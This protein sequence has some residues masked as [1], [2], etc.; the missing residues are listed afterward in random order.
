MERP[1][2]TFQAFQQWRRIAMQRDGL[3]HSRPS[4]I[5]RHSLSGLFATMGLYTLSAVPYLAAESN[6][7]AHARWL[8]TSKLALPAQPLATAVQLCIEPGWHTYWIN[9]GESGMAT[10]VRWQLPA[11]W[12]CSSLQHPPP[13]RFT[14]AGLTSF[15]HSG[16]VWF[17]VTVTPPGDFRGQVELHGKLSWL[18][19]NETGCFPGEATITLQLN[20]G[21]P[22]PSPHHAAILTATRAL[23]QTAKSLGWQVEVHTVGQT[24]H[25]QLRPPTSRPDLTHWEVFPISLETD[26]SQPIRFQ[27]GHGERWNATAPLTAYAPSPLRELRWLLVAPSPNQPVELHW[28]AH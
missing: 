2:R 19:C 21:T 6:G 24:L 3:Q 4:S 8:S 20:A 17:P 11:G 10:S 23:P 22:T 26:P 18:A 14:N 27:H 25:V 28:S 7:H 9:P 12:Q 1:M 15:G 13:T 5:L 16:E